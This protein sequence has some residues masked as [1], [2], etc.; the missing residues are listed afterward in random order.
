M[1]RDQDQDLTGTRVTHEETTALEETTDR[2]EIIPDKIQEAEAIV[3]IDEAA[4]VTS[5]V[6]SC[7]DTRGIS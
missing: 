6:G 1:Y 2:R 3:T 5:Q 4:V 7:L